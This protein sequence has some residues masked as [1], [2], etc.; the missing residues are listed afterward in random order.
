MRTATLR[1]RTGQ[2]TVDTRNARDV[3]YTTSHRGWMIE[4][5]ADSDGT[6]RAEASSD[7][8]WFMG[9][10]VMAAEIETPFGALEEARDRIDAIERLVALYTHPNYVARRSL[11]VGADEETQPGGRHFLAPRVLQ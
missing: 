5:L 1:D 7:D 8:V 2:A 10:V 4:V 11:Q 3:R 6:W 9:S